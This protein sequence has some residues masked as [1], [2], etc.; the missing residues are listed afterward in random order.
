[1]SEEEEDWEHEYPEGSLGW[2]INRKID[3]IE[4]HALKS[5]AIFL[6]ISTVLFSPVVVEYLYH[7]FQIWLEGIEVY[8][9]AMWNTIVY[10]FAFLVI[11]SLFFYYGVRLVWR[12]W[13]RKEKSL[14]AKRRLASGSSTFICSWNDLP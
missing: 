1:M 5:G 10:A 6:S 3:A 14:S 7:P 4:E 12:G 9:L 8:S 2:K 13:K 11:G